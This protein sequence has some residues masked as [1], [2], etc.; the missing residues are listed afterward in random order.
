MLLRA[1]LAASVLAAVAA[2][3]SGRA[4]A[5]GA[6]PLSDPHVAG[7]R[8]PE[9]E[10]TLTSW[11]TQSARAASVEERDAAAAKIFLHGW[12]LWTA[13]TAETAQF[14]ERQ[15]LRQF[16]TWLTPEELA[17][18]PDPRDVLA[19]APR[20]TLGT[21]AAP[22]RAVL[23]P[24]NQLR[25]ASEAE[26]NDSA[27]AAA[28]FD[29]PVTRVVGFVKFDPTAADHI[30]QQGL[31]RRA[32]LDL[33]LDGGAQQVPPF[34]S[35]A[36]VV[37]PVFQVIRARDLVAGRYYALKAWSGPPATPQPWGPA[38]WS[39]AV[40]LDVLDGGS[41]SGAIDEPFAP[42]GSTRTDDTTYPLSAIIHYRLSATDAAALNAAKPG[43]DAAGG[44][45]AVLVAMHVAGREIA[46]WTW[47]TFWWTPA[48]DTPP[49]PS[50][51]AIV[52]AR[53]VELAGPARHYA[54]A[55]AY[56]MLSP[57]QPYVGGDN[58]APAVY[59]YNP[60]LEAGLRPV[61]LPDSRPGFDPLGQPAANNTGVQTNCM[62]CHIQATYNP[63]QLA[64]APR[65]TGA[66]YVDLGAA[67]FVGTL[68]TE[69]L[70]SI[71]RHAQ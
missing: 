65:F 40:W 8:F 30:R 43:T 4:Q 46:R 32:T 59:A 11:I 29:L 68:Q 23:R 25:R 71:S 53:P 34:P 47:Q 67:G 38:E 26:D 55:V 56:A 66:R 21:A 22:R 7:F 49:A 28:V 5:P 1:F 69:F 41:G 63:Q 50:S 64:T 62:S 57:D 12:G 45:I 18:L 51:A 52:R 2:G 27:A 54:M 6:A 10:A 16:E 60:W 19:I 9:T 13:I 44:D 14:S 3:P 70:W 24:L 15:R 31:L 58:V 36:L 42:D 48:P 20:R 37:K 39:G 35:T 33:L 17:G 61:D